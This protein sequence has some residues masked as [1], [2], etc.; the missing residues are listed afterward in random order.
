MPIIE[1]I[2]NSFREYSIQDKIDINDTERINQVLA[3]SPRVNDSFDSKRT[4]S[5]RLPTDQIEL[6]KNI[7]WSKYMNP[8]YGYEI[9]YPSNV[10]IGKPLSKEEFNPALTGNY[11]FLDNSSGEFKDSSALSIDAFH[12]DEK[13]KLKKLF[14]PDSPKIQENLPS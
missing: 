2:T 12:R 10:G 6:I 8:T 4:L 5:I 13:T 7:Q 14:S 11:F 1:N 3:S 9:D